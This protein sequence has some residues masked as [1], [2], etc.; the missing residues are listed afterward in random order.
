MDGACEAI[1]RDIVAP[2]SGYQ[3]YLRVLTERNPLTLLGTVTAIEIQPDST[4]AARF[5]PPGRPCPRSV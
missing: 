5:S 4:M 2:T 1:A 3:G